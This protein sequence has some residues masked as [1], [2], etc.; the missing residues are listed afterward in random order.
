MIVQATEIP[1][2]Y[3]VVGVSTFGV[4]HWCL[5]NEAP[6]VTVS[7]CQLDLDQTGNRLVC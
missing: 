5:V 3:E 7:V 2:G 1:T 6:D 4:E